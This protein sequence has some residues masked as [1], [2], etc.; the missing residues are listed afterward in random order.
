MRWLTAV[1]VMTLITSCTSSRV[2]QL[3]SANQNQRVKVLVMHFTALNYAD[4]V[5]ALVDEGG[6]SSHYLIPQNNDESYPYG[7]LKAFQLVD[8]NARA[9]HAGESYW[10]GMNGLND[11]SIGIEIVNIPECARDQS[12]SSSRAENAANRVCLYPDYDPQQ[13]E[14]LISLS[15]SILARNPDIHPTAVVGHA[16]IAPHR[17]NDPGPRFP[18]FELYKAGIGAW[19]DN[20]TYVNYW[21]TFNERLPTIEV[22]QAALSA[23]GYNIAATGVL[24]QATRDVLA[25]FQMHFTP[26]QVTANN[27]SQTNAAIFALLEKYF[28]G[29]LKLMLARYERDPISLASEPPKR[30]S[31]QIDRI[32]PDAELSDS[33]WV[34]NKARFKAYQGRGSI[35]LENISEGPVS[36][37][38]YI[39]GEKL[40]LA[41]AFAPDTHYQ[42]SLSRR[43]RDGINALAVDNIEPDDG[44]LRIQISYPTLVDGLN[45]SIDFTAVDHL[46]NQD[47]DAGFPGAVLL[48][49]H[50]GRV[51]KHQAYGF[52]KRYDQQGSPLS[53]PAPM[54]PDTLFDVA[55]NT[56]IFATTLAIMSLVE[57]GQ[58]DVD[59]P[60]YHYLPE[61]RGDGRDARTT[62]DLLTH[63]AGFAPEVKFFMRENGLGSRFFSQNAEQT[64]QLLL[65]QVPLL[66]SNGTAMRYSDTSFML[67]GILVE[68]ITGMPL[69]TFVESTIY[70][71]LG[72]TD[73][74]FNPKQKRP[75]DT[76]YAATELMGNTRN[77]HIHFENVR[78]YTLE[79]EVHDEKAYYSMQGVSGHAG[80]FSTATDL[81]VMAQLL[82]NGGG[83]GMHHLLSES[84]INQ[85]VLPSPLDT[86]T[87]LGFRR[88]AGGE[89]RWQFGPYASERAFGHTGWTGTVSVIDPEQDLIII[90]LTNKRHTPVISSMDE[91]GNQTLRFVGDEYETGRYG[92][93]VGLIYEAVLFSQ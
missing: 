16:D 25:A 60:L 75:D 63:S 93:I 51:I 42:Y 3:P 66:H 64:K 47:I 53:N 32:F 74:L 65:T 6:L 13:I 68:R 14:L 83:Y 50:K 9:W 44:Q 34:N 31:G 2:E 46:I 8:E 62:R 35:T 71:T 73:T 26:W 87:G 45:N 55:S 39:N 37:D 15:Q 38:V 1:I 92:S 40:N 77:G 61:F 82:L 21:R 19:Y 81:A 27:D 18:W 67:L 29:K 41:D 58:L 4:S 49:A 7:S 59:K 56:K 22:T 69:D 85:F 11:Q 5:K 30:Q 91:E 88:A 90:L 20:D 89:R 84:V 28:P 80:L 78:E 70:Q 33:A 86:A 24:D 23:Y 79:G 54:T 10:Q 72:L 12:L 52:A 17:K 43:T 48:V 76:H 57:Q 36:A